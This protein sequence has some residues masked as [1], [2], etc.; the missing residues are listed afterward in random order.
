MSLR[1]RT[2]R[3]PGRTRAFRWGR[4]GAALVVLSVGTV[5]GLGVAAASPPPPP[6]TPPQVR[7]LVAASSRIN[8]VS[9][10]VAA[11]LSNEL[12]L[13]TQVAYPSVG[14]SCL[15]PT[16]CV[17]GA[18]SSR[19][20]IVLFGDS[21][22]LMWLP[23]VIAAASKRYRV[24]LF[25]APTCPLVAI[26]NM[27]FADSPIASN[28]SS[29]RTSAIALIKKI[30]PRLV[31][32]GERTYQA[33]TMPGDV[34]ISN[35]QWITSLE[36]TIRSI[37]TART[38]VALVEDPIAFTHNPLQCVASYQTAIQRRCSVKNPNVKTPS[39][40]A[41]E[42]VAARAT[43]ITF[44][45]TVPWFCTTTC[46]PVVGNNLVHYDQGHVAVPYARYLATVFT[47]ALK[48]DL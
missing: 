22:A 4:L 1:E 45:M 18:A 30:A 44:V 32:L 41:A 27:A 12:S 13:K 29:Y 3:E 37:R 5:A 43:G 2:E 10:A 40:Q 42:R 17:F 16:P 35:A 38:K 36:A 26:P 33:F 11:E 31:I 47:Q 25:W 34:P 39:H 21:H 24:D 6:G 9:P 28:C 15:P 8:A 23:D 48:G 46:S 14:Q 20:T 19:S 7:A